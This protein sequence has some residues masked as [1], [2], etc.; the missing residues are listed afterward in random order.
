MTSDTQESHEVPRRAWRVA[1]AAAPAGIVS[2]T[3]V[4][5]H[6]GTHEMK[7][8]NSRA[9]LRSYLTHCSPVDPHPTPRIPDGCL[10]RTP[11]RW[12]GRTIGRATGW[13]S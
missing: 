2:R 4:R 1:G 9:A 3:G 7:T 5:C 10:P 12:T 6:L 8:Q 13:S 11:S